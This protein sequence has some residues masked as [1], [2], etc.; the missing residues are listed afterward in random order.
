MQEKELFFVVPTYRLRDVGETI[1]QYD[2]HFWRNGHAVRMIVFDDSSPA[3][4]EKYYA[5]LEK[6]RT[7][8]DLYY[9]GPREKEQFIAYLSRRLRDKRLDGLV[10]NLFRP[11]YGGNRNFTLMYTLGGLMISADDDMRPYTLLEDSPESLGVD[12]V[13]RGRLLKAGSNGY[14][15][16]SFDILSAFLDVLG[17]TAD[18]VPSNYE[19]GELLID[20]ATDLET[21]ASKELSREN[22]LLLQRGPLSDDAI[23]KMAQTFRSGTN[24]IDALDFVEMFLAN[25][26]QTQVDQ[27]NDIYVLVNFRPAVTNK[28]WRM[29]CGV[30]G[31]DNTFGLPPF[32]PTRLRFEDY[33]YRLW[34]QQDG[35][36]A[37]HVDAAQHHTKNNYM[38]NPPA[39]EIFNE[40]VSNLLKRKIKSTVSRLDELTIVFDYDGEVTAQDATEILDKIKRLH[41]RTLAA[42]PNARPERADALRVFAANLEKAFYGLEPDFFQQNLLRIVDDVVSVIKGSI[43]LW[44]TLV[45][46]CY[47]QKDRKG[48]PQTRVMNQRKRIDAGRN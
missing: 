20:T 31:Y 36:A 37:A 6:T 9:V 12:E 26:S 4:H 46:I 10:K 15:R 48:L 2:E 33:I 41:A 1:E 7:F 13:C 22:S 32:F 35:I 28:N 3:N 40:E 19:R 24:D 43:E 14:T 47:F 42:V 44:P 11:S 45:E 8:N 18:Q 38:R 34:V 17:K 39:A 21:N 23:V 5:Q 29:D 16:K 25:E 30:A 27:L